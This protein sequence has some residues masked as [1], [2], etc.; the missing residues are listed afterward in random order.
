MKTR[1]ESLADCERYWA[2]TGIPGSAVVAM[3][4][5]LES[6]LRQAAAEGKPPETVVGA[7]LAAFAEAWAREEMSGGTLPTWAEVEAARSQ[8]RRIGAWATA[9]V[10]AVAVAAVLLVVL[11]DGGEETDM[12]E[13]TWIWIWLGLAVIFA[14]GEVVTAGFFM[15]PFAVG[16]AASFFVTI[17]GGPEWLQLVTFIVV[18]VIALLVLRTYVRTEDER[19][20]PVGANR[21]LGRS[22]VVMEDIDPITGI[23]R[24]KMDTEDWRAVSTGARIPAGTPV[25]IVGVTGT[26]LVVETMAE[27][28][29]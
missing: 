7:D 9:A 14:F 10:S 19:Q 23:G 5:E 1:I 12:D 29:E 24:V 17:V 6:H 28:E 25:K 22:G 11:L 15:L 18:S 27:V 20:F 16:A 3:R 2:R 26:R 13:T 4:A 21:Y 8:G